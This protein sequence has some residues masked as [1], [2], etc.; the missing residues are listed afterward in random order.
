LPLTPTSHPIL[1]HLVFLGTGTSHGVP[2][3]GCHCPVCRST[4]PRD[5]RTRCSV[6]LGLPEGN[7]LIDTPPELRLQLVRQ[8]IGLVHAVAYTHAHADHLFGVDDLRIFGEY[9]GHDLPVYCDEPVEQR[10]RKVL[11]YAFDPDLDK[12]YAGGV[13]RLALHRI[14]SEPMFVLGARLIPIPV[15]HGK[16][17]ILGYRIG[18]LAY[19]TDTNHIPEQSFDLLRGIDTLVLDCLRRTPH[20]T[21]YHLDQ[22]LAVARQIGA[23]KTYFTHMCH[24][25]GH[26]ATNRELPPGIE[27]AYD[28]LTLPFE[29]NHPGPK[30]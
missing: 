18:N 9:L 22:A 23:K 1:G 30:D 8:G 4:D 25:L 5:H 2:V 17:R 21:H 27:L 24:D 16:S 7:L 29:S 3:I 20:P 13:P 14:T 12:R 11:D 26:A 15:F 28:G 10:L 19:C 6:V